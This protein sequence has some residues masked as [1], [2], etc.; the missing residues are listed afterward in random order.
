MPW[1]LWR[2]WLQKHW[3]QHKIVS[4]TLPTVFWHIWCHQVSHK[5]CPTKVKTVP[6]ER[7]IGFVTAWYMPTYFLLLLVG[8]FNKNYI[9]KLENNDF[10]QLLTKSTNIENKCRDFY[11]VTDYK[12]IDYNT[13]LCLKL[14]LQFFA[15]DFSNRKHLGERISTGKNLRKATCADICWYSIFN[16]LVKHETSLHELTKIKLKDRLKSLANFHE[17]DSYHSCKFWNRSFLKILITL[18]NFSSS[19]PHSNNYDNP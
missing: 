1:L 19:F 11:D 7:S 13:K 10:K 17:V 5:V 18:K 16:A 3:L 8:N 15:T 14:C 9:M 12:N 4:K 2:H 6:K